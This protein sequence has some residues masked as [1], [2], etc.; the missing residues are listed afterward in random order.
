MLSWMIKKCPILWLRFWADHLLSLCRSFFV[1]CYTKITIGFNLV[2]YEE[3]T[4][5]DMFIC[6]VNHHDFLNHI[7][8][9]H[10]TIGRVGPKVPN[11]MISSIESLSHP[12]SDWAL[13]GFRQSCQLYYH[14]HHP[15]CYHLYA[16]Y[17]QF[18]LH[19]MLFLHEICFVLL[20]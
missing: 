14:H 8:S 12:S 7:C 20:H 1:F 5:S 16:G 9:R 4:V 10:W 19:I 6:E 15:P 3:E 11:Q 17:L 13:S 2:V 18:M